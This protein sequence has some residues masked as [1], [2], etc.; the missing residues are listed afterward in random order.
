MAVERP[1]A[2][3]LSGLIFISFA[4]RRPGPERF[5][6]SLGMV[7]VRIPAGS[8]R[9]G[10]ELPTGPELGYSHT[11]P[12]GDPDERPVRTVRIGRDFYISETEVT[13]EQFARFRADYVPPGNMHPWATGVSWEDAV[14]FCEWLSRVEARPYRLP[15]EAEWE[16]V[17]RAGS[18]DHFSSGRRPPPSGAPNRFGVRNMHTDA[19]E[20]VLDW[21]GPYPAEDETDPVGPAEGIARV[22]RG[23]GIASPW[24]SELPKYPNAGTLPYFRR[25][26]N[27]ASAPP[28]WRG[29][30]HIG[31]RV[32][33]APMPATPPRPRERTWLETAVKQSREHVRRGPDPARPWFRR[34]DVLTVPPTD[35]TADEI[36]V[37]GLCPGIL[38]YMHHAALTVCPNGDLLAAYFSAP[39]PNYED[40]AS[41]LVIGFRLRFGAEQWDMPSPMLDLADIKDTSPL[42]AT[43]GDTV[44]LFAGGSGL[45]GVPFRW[46]VSRDSGVTWSPLLLPLIEGPRWDSSS[47]PIASLLRAADGTLYLAADAVGPASFLWASSDGGRTWRD[48]GG[49][50]G[51]RHTVFALLRDGRILGLGG[52]GGAIEGYMPQSVSTDGGRSWTVSK[53]PFPAVGP[54][55]QRPALLRLASGRLFLASDWQDNEGRQ[56]PGTPHRGAF[57]ALSDDEGRTWRIK[58][59][60]GVRPPARL[61]LRHRPGWPEDPMKEP[62]LG[63]PA[64]VQAPNGVIHLITSY[65]HPPQHFEMNEAWILSDSEAPSAGGDV[66]GAR[67]FSQE[68]RPDGVRATWS[69]CIDAH[70]R[71]LLD[72]PER[73]QYPGGAPMYEAHWE[74]GHKR[75]LERFWNGSGRLL[76]QWERHGDGSAVW[77]RFWPNGRKRTESAWRGGR[78]EGVAR[79]WDRDGRL[80]AQI[81]FAG[82]EKKNWTVADSFPLP[83]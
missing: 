39:I 60:P 6:N 71:Y 77:T 46:R 41:V 79:E 8:F 59:L 82:G 10:N 48:T 80:V 37:A 61:A 21:Y 7:M 11:A 38:G 31:F 16:Y 72:G 76:W 63:Y 51:G 55:K 43:V 12:K 33:Q 36:R 4:C 62:T 66:C 28:S 50:T 64:A 1:L 49:R 22:V 45:T 32:V 42:L 75:G 23:G 30:H 65:N 3:A 13:A 73:W 17:A 56:P 35:S 29:P 68:T 25:S 27:R 52:K 5:T 83:R 20:W 53:S 2:F 54:N 47:Q 15:T 19:A 67:L 81:E 44:Y 69:G 57:V 70:G 9:M 58:N 26:A 40:L 74:R 18:Q 78:A 34:R 24:A 14:A